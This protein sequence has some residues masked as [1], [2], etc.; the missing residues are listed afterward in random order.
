MNK[1]VIK[2][3]INYIN[4]RRLT[5]TVELLEQELGISDAEILLFYVAIIQTTFCVGGAL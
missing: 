2:Q 1:P 5:D 3:L 4:Q